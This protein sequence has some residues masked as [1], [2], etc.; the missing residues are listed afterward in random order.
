MGEP[1]NGMGLQT[2]R[3]D[4]WLWATRF[5]RSRNEAARACEE[6][7]VK[8]AGKAVKAAA[9]V[10]GGELLEVGWAEGPGLRVVRVTGL[11]EKRV[12]PPEARLN[13]EDLTPEETL[14][15]RREWARNRSLRMEGEQGRPT[16]KKRREMERGGGYF[17]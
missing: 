15:M 2:V 5:Y 8:Q 4:K 3:I 14:A 12:G 11:I 10:K 6:G 1:L 16:K 13:Y 17:D 9:A 7:K